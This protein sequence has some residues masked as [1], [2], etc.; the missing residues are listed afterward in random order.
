ML[1]SASQN[2]QPS[3]AMHRPAPL[4]VDGYTARVWHSVCAVLPQ[5]HANVNQRA[6]ESHRGETRQLHTTSNGP[7]K[8]PPTAGSQRVDGIDPWR[9]RAHRRA[10]GTWHGRRDLGL[11]APPPCAQWPFAPAATFSSFCSISRFW[12]FSSL[13]LLAHNVTF[14]C[15][16]IRHQV[17]HLWAYECYIMLL[18]LRN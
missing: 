2:P 6:V 10:R 4:P 9:H 3:P 16:P 1:L 15:P 7:A 13:A 12:D 11:A 17:P 18:Q 5:K 14:V 8:P